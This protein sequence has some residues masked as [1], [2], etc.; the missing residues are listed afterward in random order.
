MLKFKNSLLN[1]LAEEFINETLKQELLPD[2]IQDVVQKAKTD[3][4]FEDNKYQTST[5]DENIA[6]TAR[7]VLVSIDTKHRNRDNE[8]FMIFTKLKKN[9]A[10]NPT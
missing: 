2:L 7:N 4:H 1:I 10:T 5:I 9:N 8:K 6:E 3:K